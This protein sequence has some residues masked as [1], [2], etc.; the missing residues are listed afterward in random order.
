M[1]TSGR[2]KQ[3]FIQPKDDTNG[4]LVVANLT[5]N[6]HSIENEL[7]D[8]QTKMGRILQYGNNNESFELTAYGEKG[9]AG[10]QA[11][12][13]AIRNK[14]NLLVWETDVSGAGPYDAQ[15]AEVLV[16]SVERSSASDSFEE[17]SATFQV[18]GESVSGE[19]TALPSGFTTGTST[20]FQEPNTGV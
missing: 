6:S 13:D 3:L 9:D 16:E 11:V 5:E 19:L 10:Q 1:P 20:T 14:T 15:Y 7:M 8:E 12:L 4:A 2:N 17:I 18:F